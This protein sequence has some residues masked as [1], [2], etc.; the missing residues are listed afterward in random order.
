MPQADV[1]ILAVA[2]YSYATMQQTEKIRL[3][4]IPAGVCLP[5]RGVDY[6]V[7]SVKPDNTGDRHCWEY[8]SL[9]RLGFMPVCFLK[10]R[11]K[12]N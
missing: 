8:L 4:T 9:Y 6:L 7:F 5:M 11:A 10:S 3:H 2:L 12:Y 1:M